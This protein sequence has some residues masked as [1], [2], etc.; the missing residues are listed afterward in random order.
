M[1]W[2]EI[3]P[4]QEKVLRTVIHHYILTAKP[5]GSRVLAKKYDLGLSAATLRNVMADLEEAGYLTHPH[6]SAGRVPTSH[7]YKLYVNNLMKVEKL[8]SQVK[9]RIRDNVNTIN[10]NVDDLLAKTSQILALVSRQLGVVIG[11]TIETAVIEKISLVSVASDKIL[12]IISFGAGLIK[13]VVVEVRS[14]MEPQEVIST[15][16][17]LNE[18][19]SGLHVKNVISTIGKRLCDLGKHENELVRL[20]IDSADKFFDIDEKKIF[21]GGTSNFL[22]QPEFTEQDRLKSIIELVE[23]KDVVVHLLNRTDDELGLV[24]KIGE[25]NEPDV[26]KSF[27][28][29]STEFSIGDQTGTLGVIDPPR[30]WY[31]KMIPLVEY[32]ADLINKVMKKDN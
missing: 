27:S 28:I 5:V 3:T 30:M 23:Q 4:R 24:I 17:L 11:P 26:R 2:E 1:E 19:L 25:E 10:K 18:R 12:I 7:G 31:P 14:K 21:I 15:S 32:T 9:R 20:F 29:V 6:T 8:T 13:S 22:D 16:Q